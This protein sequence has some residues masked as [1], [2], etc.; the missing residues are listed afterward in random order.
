MIGTVLNSCL[1]APMVRSVR[2]RRARP[3]TCSR[4]RN[5]HFLPLLKSTAPL[6]VQRRAISH[7]T[8]F[9]LTLASRDRF[10]LRWRDHVRKAGRRRSNCSPPSL[11]GQPAHRRS[12]RRECWSGIEAASHLPFRDGSAD[13]VVSRAVVEHIRDNEA[14]FRNCAHVLRPDGVM[15]HANPWHPQ[16]GIGDNRNGSPRRCPAVKQSFTSGPAR[17]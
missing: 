2:G 14:F 6:R 5:L 3:S 4:R 8:G 11:R 16:F 7:H 12:A 17:A 9:G 15:I 13:L 1:Q 10:I